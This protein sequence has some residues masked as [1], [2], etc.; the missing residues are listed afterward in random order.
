MPDRRVTLDRRAAPFVDRGKRDDLKMTDN[1]REK[2]KKPSPFFPRCSPRGDAVRHALRSRKKKLLDRCK[3]DKIERDLD[4]RKIVQPSAELRD[5]CRRCDF[6][7]IIFSPRRQRYFSPLFYRK[8]SKYVEGLILEL[9]RIL[10]KYLL[11]DVVYF[12]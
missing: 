12:T 8:E 4:T 5:G 11:I 9:R 6:I 1:S 3:L 10:F 2:R 7:F